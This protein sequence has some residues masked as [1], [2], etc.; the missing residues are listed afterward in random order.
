MILNPTSISLLKLLSDSLVRAGE[1]IAL[2]PNSELTKVLLLTQIFQPSELC[3]IADLSEKKSGSVFGVSCCTYDDLPPYA[4]TVVLVC[5]LS[6]SSEI[7]RK[8]SSMQS[9]CRAKIIDLSPLL[10]QFPQ[11]SHFPMGPD[12][13]HDVIPALVE[14]ER[15]LDKIRSSNP[16]R[17]ELFGYKCYSQHEEDGIIDEVFR[18]VR[19]DIPRT[20]IEFG[21][22]NGLENNTLYLLK[23]G[24]S[25]LW[26]ECG[27]KNLHDI[28]HNFAACLNSEQ[29]KL[30]S[31]KVTTENINKLLA[32]YGNDRV[33]LLSID[34]DGNDYHVWGVIDCI[35]PSLVVIEYNAKFPPPKRWTISYDENHSWDY[36]DY[37]GA[38]LQLMCDLARRKGYIL[39]CCNLNGTNAFFLRKDLLNEEFPLADQIHDL[40]HPPR[41][42]LTAGYMRKSGHTP[43]ARMGCWMGE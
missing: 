33:G 27:E 25:G 11:P 43:S 41:Y 6:F 32:T 20:F 24:W 31:Q 1:R 12:S 39:V 7:I 36:T 38:S 16:N 23:Q 13:M 30:Y 37:Q 15:L 22:G 34:I 42:Y 26:I 3:A 8:L 18:R 14:I 17:L 21:V 9:L 4:P 2:C 35:R 10:Q 19:V 29:L 5:S 40:Y 28:R